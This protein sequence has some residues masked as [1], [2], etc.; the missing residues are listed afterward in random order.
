MDHTHLGMII[1]QFS[2]RRLLGSYAI[3]AVTWSRY[4]HVEFVLPTGQ[5]F[6]AQVFRGVDVN[7]PADDY[8][9]CD[10]FEVVGCPASVYDI[11]LSKKGCGYDY[12]NDIGILLHRDWVDK[13]SFQCSRFVA[14]VMKE[15]KFPFLRFEQV[16]RLTPEKLQLSPTLR[17]I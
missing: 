16:N 15:A 2:A 12:L 17:A 3:R 13:H 10:R 8:I 7:M 6:G 14:E 9:R 5:L 1:L 11:A 4:S